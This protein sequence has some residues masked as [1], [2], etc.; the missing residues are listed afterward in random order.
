MQ[1]CSVDCQ[2]YAKAG[3][4]ARFAKSRCVGFATY[5]L[6]RY[7]VTLTHAAHFDALSSDDGK[8]AVAS[9]NGMQVCMEA[10]GRYAQDGALVENACLVFAR[11]APIDT[12]LCCA[13][14]VRHSVTHGLAS[15]ELAQQLQFVHAVAAAFVAHKDSPSVVAALCQAIIP[16]C[17]RMRLCFN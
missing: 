15:S 7:V 10:M 9:A 16:L 1:W 8:T 4:E 17:K 11:V 12:G 14:D 5:Y 2:R 3:R 6:R 13:F